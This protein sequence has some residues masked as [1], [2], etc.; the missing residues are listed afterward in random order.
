MRIIILGHTGMLGQALARVSAESLVR[1][2]GVARKGEVKWDASRSSFRE[3]CQ[4]LDISESD[5]V[6]NCIGW[7]PQKSL[8]DSTMD[9]RLADHLNR[10][11]IVEIAKAQESLGFAWAQIATDCIFSTSPGPHYENSDPLPNDLY[12]ETKLA[13]EMSMQ[14]AMKIRSSIVG[15]DENYGSGLFEWFRRLPYGEIVSGYTNALWNGVT[16]LAFA[17]LIVGAAREGLI[18]PAIHHWIP[19]DT[20]TKFEL[21]EMFRD[22]LGRQDVSIVPTE[23]DLEIDRL[24]GTNSPEQNR[25]YWECAGYSKIPTIESLCE[26]MIQESVRK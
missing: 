2:V 10:A 17:R 24:L 1:S 23:L 26:E 3:L 20:A 7:I 9:A 19:R 22:L 16:T 5:V 12:G 13:G 21:L 14:G 8:G 4:K 6:A 18:K 11:L 15:H 25:I